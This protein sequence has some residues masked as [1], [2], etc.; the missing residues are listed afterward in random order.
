VPPVIAEK[1]DAAL[2]ARGLRATAQRRCIVEA[3]AELGHA[4][5]EQIYEQVRGRT[6][7]VNLS[8]VYRALELLEDLSF[9]SHTHL[10]H[11]SPT[12]HLAEQAHHLHLVCR[13]CGSVTQA[14][15]APAR[16]LAGAMAR[17]H[18]FATD[19]AHLSL[20]GLCRDC[21]ADPGSSGDVGALTSS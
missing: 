13:R 3:V 11:G 9:V 10:R 17:E 16:S 7:S 18:G 6:P 15:L 8:T 5:P 19:L 20:H 12:Y 2:R 1:L 21:A 14:D 4:T